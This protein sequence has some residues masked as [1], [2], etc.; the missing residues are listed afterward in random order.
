MADFESLNK[1]VKI[2]GDKI[3]QA[4]MKILE[5]SEK[6]GNHVRDHVPLELKM[7]NICDEISE[8]RRNINVLIS[9]SSKIKNLELITNEIKNNQMSLSF[10]VDSMTDYIAGKKKREIEENDYRKKRAIERDKEKKESKKWF[11][12]QIA[13]MVIFIS[14]SLSSGVYWV[15]GILQ[16]YT[17]NYEN[18]YVQDRYE[19]SNRLEKIGT[20]IEKVNQNYIDLLNELRKSKK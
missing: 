12:G 5:M 15:S 17:K 4:D 7:L 9:D 20:E 8:Q 16:S 3:E 19:N 2:L 10:K 6:F 11:V 18:R 13:A 14:G 1:S